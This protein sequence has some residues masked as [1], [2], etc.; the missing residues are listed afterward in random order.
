[1][2]TPFGANPYAPPEPPSYPKPGAFAPSPRAMNYTGFVDMIH[3]RPD[4]FVNALLTGVCGIIPVIGHIVVSGYCYECVEV[5][6]RTDGQFYPKFD[7]NRFGDYLL[8]GVGWFL[9]QLVLGLVQAVV[10]IASYVLF[11]VAVVGA[12]A[13]AEG[14][15][16]AVAGIAILIAL[17]LFSGVIIVLVLGTFFLQTPLGLRGGLSSEIGQAFAFGW[18]FDFVKKMW[19]EMLLMVLFFLVI[20]IAAEVFVFA[21]CLL[22]L[23]P[24]IGYIQ[25]ISAWLLFNLYRVYLSRGGQPIPF[26][27]APIPIPG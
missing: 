26:K 18:A 6:H 12:G 13:A 9:I 8:R 20:G 23:I 10:I 21:T 2:S 16:E 3:R 24:A 1:M 14:N 5:L 22:G 4:W 15:N 27:P 17:L 7:F 25:L 11:I 19:V